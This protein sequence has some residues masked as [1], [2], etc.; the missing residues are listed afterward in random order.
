MKITKS[1]LKQIIKEELARALSEDY[2]QPEL[3]QQLIAA[4]YKNGQQVDM[5]TCKKI[6]DQF[7]EA[8]GDQLS[9]P[10]TY[11]SDAAGNKIGLLELS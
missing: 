11:S 5:A 10:C 4:G 3:M 8:T 6:N 2:G 9:G 1:Q 7:V